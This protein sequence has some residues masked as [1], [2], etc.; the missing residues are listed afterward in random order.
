MRHSSTTVDGRLRSALVFS[1]LV[2]LPTVTLAADEPLRTFLDAY[3]L[4]CHDAVTSKGGLD[5]ENLPVDFQEPAAFEAWVKVHD[6]IETGEMPP[7]ARQERPNRVEAETVLLGLERA[8]ADADRSRRSVDGRAVFRRLNA[9]EY[10][11]TLRDL[12]GIPGLRV[13]DLLPEDGRAFGYDKC[14]AGL[15]LSHVQLARYLEAAAVALDVAITPHAAPPVIQKSHNV[16]GAQAGLKGVTLNGDA[17][18]LKDGK[19]DLATG[20]PVPR[21]KGDLKVRDLE[22]SG[23]F[24]YQGSIGIFRHE[25]DAFRPSFKTF[26]PVFAGRYRLRVSLWS[27]A[28]DKGEVKPNPRTEAA[29]LVAGGR[30]LGYFDAPSLKPTVHEVEVWLN[31]GELIYFNAASLFPVRVSERPGRAAEYVG[32]G[33]A[34]DF[35]DVEGPILDGWPPPGHRRLFG[36]LTM[37]PLPLALQPSAR[38]KRAR[39]APGS[40]QGSANQMPSK[41]F[42]PEMK[43]ELSTVAPT[44]PEADATRL[45]AG[46]LGRAFRRPLAEDEVRR[47][48][49]LV[50][51]HLATKV[52][53]ETAMRRAYQAALCSPDF[54]FLKEPA[55]QLDP[56]ALACRLSYF[57]WNSMPDD[58]LFALAE[59]GRLRDPDVLRGQVERMLNDPKA[60]RLVVDFTDQWLDLRDIDDTTPDKKLYPEF[61]PIL[62]DAMLAE[63]RAFFRELL[64]KDLPAS[65]VVDSDF[66]MLNQRLAE[67]YG[68]T[69][70]EG[71]AIRRV[72]L[73][74]DSHRGGFLTQAAVLKVTANGTTT[75]PVK[76]GAWV[77]RKIVGQPPEPPPPNVPAIEPDVRGTTTIREMLAR[78]RSNASCA[79]C[80]AKIDPPGFALESFDVIGGW[81]TRY[82]SL[83]E[84]DPVDKERTG[85]RGVGYKLAQEVDAAGQ[86][87]DGRPFADI[88]E[89]KAILLADPRAVARNLV[90]QLVVYATGAPVGFADRAAVEAVLDKTAETRYGIRSLIHEI[91]Q[92]PLFLTK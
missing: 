14:A 31:P 10:E 23:V 77:Q 27:F 59:T 25:D 20:I 12:F 84:G 34:I 74:A 43:D 70:I 4:V 45:L 71:V 62:R 56:W 64:E 33:V 85:G 46:F 6:R 68:I 2:L 47:Y 18:F 53:F 88:E 92:S 49:G 80:H 52:N 39:N 26:Y 28:W 15:D 19:Y 54:L 21:G 9:T 58:A 37:I 51:A 67:H 24:P 75:S 3:C 55:G 83:G 72:S 86:T 76:R 32:A 22:Q 65:N 82:R 38:G 50:Q 89:F 41:K 29:S 17:V 63:T 11:N 7:K 90:G 69:G 8:L 60:E 66:A 13:K 36:D 44:D 78:H 73:A 57:L 16:P 87:A 81:Q 48:V 42:M 35:L 79:A 61:R 40:A 1:A 91:V 30:V 5:L